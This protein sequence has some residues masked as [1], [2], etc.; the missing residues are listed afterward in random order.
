MEKRNGFTLIELMVVVLIVA[1]LAAIAIPVMR[2]RIDTAKW[3]EAIAGADTIRTSIRAYIAEHG[4]H[5]DYD[6]LLGC[7]CGG[8]IAQV[9]G[10]T[11]GELKGKYFD[12]DSYEI[13][14]IDIDL[15]KATC[16]IEVTPLEVP[17]APRGVGTLDADGHW[18]VEY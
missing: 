1:I 6:E 15:K 16:V 12:Q 9:L 5:H 4:S 14:D 13:T 7:L 11:R 18:S 3:A 10:F 2:G 8:P 17:G